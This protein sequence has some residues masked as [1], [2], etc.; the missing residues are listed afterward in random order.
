MTDPRYIGTILYVGLAIFAALLAAGLLMQKRRR[1]VQRTALLWGAEGLILLLDLYLCFGLLPAPLRLPVSLTVGFL[2]Y[3]AVFIAVSA[4]GFVRTA[5]HIVTA[6]P[7]LLAYRKYGRPLLREVSGFR[8]QS[9]K[10]LSAVSA[11]YFFLFI[12]L[13]SRIRLDDGVE[14]DTLFAFCST[15]CTYA[16]V[17]VLS[18]GNIFYM[19]RDAREALVK[20]KLEYLAS[21]METVSRAERESRRIRHDK[22]HHDAYIAAMA[23]AGDT[24]GI[25]RYLEQ[26]QET[27]ESFPAWCPH[28]MVNELLRSYAEKAKAAGVAFTAQ[29]DTP[30]QSDVADVDFVAI[31]ANLLENA[32]HACTAAHSAGPIRVHIRNVGKKTVLAV[33]NPCVSLALENGLPAE[34][35]VG[36]DSIVS[37]AERYQGEVHYKVEAGVCTALRHSQSIDTESGKPPEGG[38][39]FCP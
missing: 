25:L 30:A 4:D 24:D 9:W 31:L 26:E 3:S 11:I 27:V 23:R 38:F 35:S 37:A 20:Q 6:L 7:I 17:S 32:L 39:L 29:A 14:P 12:A 21:Y 2:S 34:R 33:S 5:L 8:K 28:P 16:A 13:M 22:R 1:S 36:I 15:V 10:L 18:I 19:R